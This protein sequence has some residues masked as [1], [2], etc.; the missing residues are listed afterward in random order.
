[1]RLL[2]VASVACLVLAGCSHSSSPPASS[3]TPPASS[4]AS[5]APSTGSAAVPRFTHI[6]VVVEEN[7]SESEVLG[8]PDAPYLNGL[9][10]SGAQLTNSFAIRHPSEPNY[11]AL[12]SGSTHGLTDDS[13]PHTYSTDNLGHQLLARGLSFAG[14]SESLPSVGFQGCTAGLYARKHAPWVN[15]ADLPATINRPLSALPTDWSQLPTV[16]FVIP[17]LDDDMHNGTVSQA[18]SWLRTHLGGYATWAQTHNSLLIVTWDED[19]STAANHIPG[20]L[21]GAHVK[22]GPYAGRVDHYTMLRTIEA[23]YGLPPL[24]SAAQRT[25]ITATWVP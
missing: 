3:S 8:T 16:A 12:F 21:A 20:V 15:F 24:G 10:A 5:P 18:D 25:P 4:S 1:M 6:V 7:R 23:A 9:A 19:D 13:C 11:V 22:P 17:N 14:Y 2:A